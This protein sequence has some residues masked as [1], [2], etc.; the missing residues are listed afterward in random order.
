MLFNM[1]MTKFGH[2]TFCKIN[3]QRSKT[4]H[5]R[6]NSSKHSKIQSVKKKTPVVN[7]FKQIFCLNILHL[8]QSMI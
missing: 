5:H 7:N 4:T 8:A 1:S 2:V 6:D 3:S